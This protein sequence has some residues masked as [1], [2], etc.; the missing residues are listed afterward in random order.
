MGSLPVETARKK[1]MWL[2]PKVT[3]LNP[4]ER[5]GHSAC[6]ARGVL[7][8]FGVCI[9]VMFLCLI[10]KQWSGTLFASTGQGPG[11]R[12]SHSAV[13][14]GHRMIVFGGTNGSKKVND[15][16]ILNLVTKE[17]TRPECTGTPPSPAVKATLPRL[18][19]TKN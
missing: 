5:W 15:L 9:S 1:A 14:L 13:V 16:H 4:S 12:D 7:Y 6:Y 8:V 19:V 18:L 3:G 2:Y 11:P 10:L 17:W